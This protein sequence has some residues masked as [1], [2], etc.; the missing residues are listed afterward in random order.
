MDKRKQQVDEYLKMNGE[1]EDV[2]SSFKKQIENLTTIIV[3]ILS[4]R[5]VH[6]EALGRAKGKH[7]GNG[8]GRH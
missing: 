3:S 8:E 4:F 2:V 6:R 5:I 7:L 1:H